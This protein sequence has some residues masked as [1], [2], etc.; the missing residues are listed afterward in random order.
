MRSDEQGSEARSREKEGSKRSAPT[1]GGGF[2]K[3]AGS[4]PWGEARKQYEI[5]NSQ[6][7]I[8]PAS[9]FK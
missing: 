8:A 2:S 9:F 4:R 3:V 5:Q 6:F 1:C 7:K